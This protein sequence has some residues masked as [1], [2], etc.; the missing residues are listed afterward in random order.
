VFQHRRKLLR[1]VLHS[2]F[3][4]HLDK[5]RVDALIASLDL[6]GTARAEELSVETLLRLGEAVRPLVT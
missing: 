5:P 4:Q 3:G 2:A 6:A 1:G